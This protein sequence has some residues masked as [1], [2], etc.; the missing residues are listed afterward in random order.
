MLRVEL[1]LGTIAN[2]PTMSTLAAFIDEVSAHAGRRY[3][4]QS[5]VFLAQH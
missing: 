4:P 5:F 3:A 2:H 1:S